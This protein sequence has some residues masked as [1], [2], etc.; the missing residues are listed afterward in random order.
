M[1]EFVAI[2]PQGWEVHC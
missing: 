2:L 1:S